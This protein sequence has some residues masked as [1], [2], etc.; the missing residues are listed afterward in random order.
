LIVEKVIVEHDHKSATGAERSKVLMST[1]MTGGTAA[2][3]A[4]Q[5]VG[6]IVIDPMRAAKL[7]SCSN[8]SCEAVWLDQP[9]P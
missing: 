3:A 6:A 1:K 5:C 9:Q 8:K 2:S 4:G 7:N